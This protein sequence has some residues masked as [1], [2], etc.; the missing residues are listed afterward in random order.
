MPCLNKPTSHMR[1][2][3][4]SRFI[5][6][7]INQKRTNSHKHLTSSIFCTYISFNPEKSSTTFQ[8]SPFPTRFSPQQPTV[9]STS[10]LARLWPTR[11]QPLSAR[12]AAAPTCAQKS[13]LS[14]ERCGKNGKRT[15]A[16]YLNT[17]IREI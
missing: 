11:P 1:A 12:T 15:Y 16:Y 5:P 7:P 10:V 9:S 8:A 14:G 2:L 3:L 6:L 4:R 17:I 13:W